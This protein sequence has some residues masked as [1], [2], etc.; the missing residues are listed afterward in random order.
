MR[1]AVAAGSRLMRGASIRQQVFRPT[2]LSNSPVS[3]RRWTQP[4]AFSAT[5]VQTAEVD[6][7]EVDTAEAADAPVKLKRLVPELENVESMSEEDIEAAIAMRKQWLL[8]VRRTMRKLPKAGRRKKKKFYRSRMN[9]LVMDVRI[10]LR[11][12]DI[13]ARSTQEIKRWPMPL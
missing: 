8:W 5:A 10:L 1:R 13:L 9:P 2:R 3:T 7:A 6:T 12:R 11:Q 4:R